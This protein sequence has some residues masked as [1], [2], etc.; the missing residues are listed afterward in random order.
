MLQYK[1]TIKSLRNELAA[2]YST[3]NGVL[4]GRQAVER[5][6]SVGLARGTWTEETLAKSIIISD[7]EL[8]LAIADFKTILTEINKLK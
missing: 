3:L 5:D 8:R 7:S 1:S 6:R 4:D 2:R